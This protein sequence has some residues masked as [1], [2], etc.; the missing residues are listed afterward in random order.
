M[1]DVLGYIA[2]AS[3]TEQESTHAQKSVSF[4]KRLTSGNMITS[5]KKKCTNIV[6]SIAGGSKYIGQ[7][8]IQKGREGREKA[9]RVFMD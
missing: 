2:P 7:T 3:D 9:V 6:M 5:G 4:F 8:S 1:D